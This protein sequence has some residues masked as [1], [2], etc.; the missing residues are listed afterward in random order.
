MK[1]T[2]DALADEADGLEG[3]LAEA[4]VVASSN[5]F[6]KLGDERVPE[7]SGKFDGGDGGDYLTRHVASAFILSGEGSEGVLLELVARL[8]VEGF[9]PVGV[10]VLPGCFPGREGVFD[11]ETCSVTDVGRGCVV[12]Q[13]AREGG[14]VLSWV[15]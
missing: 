7:T 11:G 9:P 15:G 6:E 3:S 12:C 5:K 14:E 13:R 1:V 10:V 8:R 2:D 4:R